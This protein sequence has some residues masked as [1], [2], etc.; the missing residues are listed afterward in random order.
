MRRER[1]DPGMGR[2]EFLKNAMLGIGSV[3]L[4]R[5]ELKAA[6]NADEE[7]TALDLK[8]TCTT[9]ILKAPGGKTFKMWMP[10][11]P[12]DREQEI[13]GLTV[14]TSMPYFK[15]QEGEWQNKIVFIFIGAGDVK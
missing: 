4:G 2:R 10:I 14:N 9:E 5:S 11:P 12:G 7:T 13:T 1:I 6:T 8:I 15:T 3:V